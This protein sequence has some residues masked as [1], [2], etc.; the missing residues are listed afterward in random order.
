M[1]VNVLIE[2]GRS[3][4]TCFWIINKSMKC[5]HKSLNYEL[6]LPKQVILVDNKIS[7]FHNET[8]F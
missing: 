4:Y 1:L 3:E 2:Y 5:V 8:Q 7:R 6:V